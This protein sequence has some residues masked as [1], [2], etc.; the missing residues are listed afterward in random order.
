MF[1]FHIRY[2]HIFFITAL[3]RDSGQGLEIHATG[4]ETETQNENDVSNVPQLVRGRASTQASPELPALQVLPAGGLYLHDRTRCKGF[5]ECVSG[6]GWMSGRWCLI[7]FYS[8]RFLPQDM[9]G[10]HLLPPQNKVAKSDSKG[11]WEAYY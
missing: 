5:W 6:C 3:R 10:L 7:T 1:T 2:F 8:S 11:F 4:G 9:A